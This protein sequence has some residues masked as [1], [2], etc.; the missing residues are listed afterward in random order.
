LLRITGA[1][2]RK[3]WTEHYR[4]ILIITGGLFVPVLL[5]LTG[6]V[7]PAMGRVLKIGMIA[8]SAFFLGQ[9]W[10]QNERQHG[11]L[12][13]LLS[14]PMAPREVVAAKYVS[15]CSAVLFSVNVPGLV[16]LDFNGLFAA[17]SFALFLAAAFMAA[18][19]VSDKP[20][21]PQIP[22]WIVIL[23]LAPYQ[24]V[25]DNPGMLALIALLTTPL[26]V[27]VSAVIFQR[28]TTSVNANSDGKD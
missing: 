2:L 28:K 27:A 12:D 24:A 14:L 19:V 6:A 11:T 10:F 9:M 13:L 7:S 3:D 22:F 21:A 20:W 23:F 25:R 17:N 18:T 8:G 15:L 1:I 4:P 26:L 16:L 5:T